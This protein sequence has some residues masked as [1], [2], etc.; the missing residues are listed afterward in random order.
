[1]TDTKKLVCDW[2]KKQSGCPVEAIQTDMFT[3]KSISADGGVTYTAEDE[4]LCRYDPST[5]HYRQFLDGS[6]LCQQ[7]FSFYSRC[8]KSNNARDWLQW[9]CNTVDTENIIRTSDSAEIDCEVST[10]PQFV[11]IDDAGYTTYTMTINV[12]YTESAKGAII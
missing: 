1:M 8:K 4:I 2:L 7:S 5:A 6:R 9:I 11:S 10:L 3:V 12:E